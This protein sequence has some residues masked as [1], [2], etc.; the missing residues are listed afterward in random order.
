MNSWY[1]ITGGPSVGKTT[2]LDELSKQSYAVLPEAARAVID[3]AI[4]GGKT[5]EQI[6]GDEQQFQMDVLAMK[7][8]VEAE[9]P[10]NQIT[11]FDR[12]MHDTIAYFKLHNFPINPEVAAA[13]NKSKYS[14]VFLLDPLPRFEHD[15]ARVESE[16]M[17]AKLQDLLYQAYADHGMIPVKVPVLPPKERA[18]WVL[19]RINEPSTLDK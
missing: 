19:Q 1:V 11:F 15:Y 10:T 13:C 3:N 5:V 18:G 8:Q 7:L 14:L 9:T 16:A 17:A 4:A 6:R 2:L 12:G